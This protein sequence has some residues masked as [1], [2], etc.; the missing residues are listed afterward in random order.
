MILI[1]LTSE[2]SKYLVVNETVAP[3]ICFNFLLVFR[4]DLSYFCRH[5]RHIR[6]K[7]T[8]IYTKNGKKLKQIS[9]A[10]AP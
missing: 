6:A 4:R 2:N 5:I 1:Y 3:L 7:I 10:T 9:G 8:I